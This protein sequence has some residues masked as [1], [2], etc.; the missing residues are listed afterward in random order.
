MIY[1]GLRVVDLTRGI[2]GAYCA[3]LLT[4]LG[5][6]VVFAEPGR[7][8]LFTY[9]RTS[10]RHADRSRAAGSRAADIVLVGEPG[11]RRRA[12]TR[13]SPSRSRRSATAVPTTVSICPRRC[14]R[15]AAAACRPTDTPH[16]P[17]LTVGGQPRRVR[18]R[19][20]RGARRGDRVVAG[21]AHRV[22][23][24][25]DVSMLEAM[26]LTFVDG[27]DGDDPVSRRPAGDRPVGDDPRQRADRRRPLRRHHDR[28]DAAVARA[29]PGHGPRRPARR[30]R[31]HDDARPRHARR[32]GERASC[33][34]GRRRTPPTR[35]L[36]P[37]S[38]RA[39][40]RRSSA[41][42]PSCPRFDQLVARD[43][44]VRQPG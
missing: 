7:R 4:D 35:S 38:T 5:A 34:P 31:A 27:A 2:A 37:A 41:T 36:P 43:V 44:F 10:Q 20:L 33:A 29:L 1:D 42:A 18:H 24:H 15:R 14:C 26:Q 28:D 39:C 17:P 21:V 9:L 13:S 32:R 23:E 11:P 6:D 19:R 12:R 3:K 16:L 25:V 8:P 30:R 22:A 40:R